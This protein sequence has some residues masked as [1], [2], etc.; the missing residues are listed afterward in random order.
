M[1]NTDIAER[2]DE[3]ADLLAIEGANSF[4]VNAYR[5]AARTVAELSR[6]AADLIAAGEDLQSLPYVGKDL[7]EKIRTMVETGELPAL[8]EVEARVPPSLREL[9][10]VEGLGPKRVNALW[11]ELGVQDLDGLQQAVEAG[12]IQT[13]TGFGAKTQK[14]IQQWLEHR[15]T[16]E[17]R[18]RLDEAEAA[19]EPLI[20]YLDSIEG[21][22]R[23]SVAGSYRRRRETIGDVDV[24]LVA[25]EGGAVLERFV[26]YDEVA[27]VVSRGHTR[28]T[29]RLRSGLQVDARVVPASSYGA[30]L[31]Y[32]TGSKAHNV[33]IRGLA[34]R[35]GLKVNEYGV[36]AGEQQVAGAEEEDVFQAVGLPFIPPELREDRGEIDAAAEDRLPELIRPDD[37]RGDLQCHTDA[38][39]GRDTLE[40]MADAA[41]A[42]GYEYLAITDHSK[43]LRVANGLDEHRLAE[44]LEAVDRLNEKRSDITLLKSCEVDILP[45]GSLDLDDEI[46]ER[47]DFTLCAL[48]QGLDL[49][50]D[51]QTERVLRAMDHPAFNVFA[52]PTGRLI[53]E[54]ERAR[55]DMER[56][57]KA[58]VER[59]IVLE[60]D[61]QPKRLDLN[62]YHAMHA[63]TLGAKLV[64]STDAHSA[65]QL[66]RMRFGVDQARR[67]W[68]TAD[69]VINTRPLNALRQLLKRR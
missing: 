44:Q 36:F 34:G 16:G 52:H 65:R 9:L 20:E 55:F 51:E 33:A 15:E 31:H 12:K 50:A 61:A 42:L 26:A 49:S 59:G 27:E 8:A 45:D 3:L 28:S 46:L 13:L 67:A 17:R 23:V 53:N 18:L 68:L 43:R 1:R 29:V 25:R 19:V 22:E 60:I 57:V 40:A 7:A 58:A 56:V 4:R 39:D 64:I 66:E 5:N 35:Q 30:A 37:I 10:D 2:F 21:V 63:K 48:H 54:R 41:V 11:Q 38:S 6:E 62:D 32:F 14:A 47:L 69:D 24:L